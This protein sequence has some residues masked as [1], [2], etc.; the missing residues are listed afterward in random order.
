ML[1]NDDGTQL[2]E[3]SSKVFSA[4]NGHIPDDEQIARIF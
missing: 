3:L 1:N 4:L 2:V